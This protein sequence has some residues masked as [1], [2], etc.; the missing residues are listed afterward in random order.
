MKVSSGA[1]VP[2]QTG[3]R[4]CAE[5][6]SGTP[7]PQRSPADLP[8]YPGSTQLARRG[9]AYETFQYGITWENYRGTDDGST[10]AIPA[11]KAKFFPERSNGAFV[12]AWSPARASTSSIRSGYRCI[13]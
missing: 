2:G 4:A 3:V 8:E 1:W 12:A 7:S 6:I 10:I 9:H 11:A 13:R 5:T